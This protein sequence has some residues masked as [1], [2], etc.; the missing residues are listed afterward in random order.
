MFF[1][2]VIFFSSSVL[3][4]EHFNL[5]MKEPNVH[6][7]IP[8]LSQIEMNVHPLNALKPHL[9][10]QGSK[11]P[12]TISII[13]PTADAGMTPLECAHS[14]GN[15][16]M[17]RFNLSPKKTY[18][19]PAG[20]DTFQL[21]YAESLGDSLY[22]LQSYIFSSYKGTHCI[23]VHISKVT[24]SKDDF[25]PWFIGFTEATVKTL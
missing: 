15:A 20:E 4:D 9:R 3:A 2:L 23:E 6:I 19:S 21:R 24:N 22:Q 18:F 17:N 5:K 10:L 11:S 14:R 16:V 25:R 12:Y 7:Q 8:G 1:I 13:V